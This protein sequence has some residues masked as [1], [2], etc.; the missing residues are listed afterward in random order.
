[1]LFGE[2][3][4]MLRMSAHMSQTELAKRLNVSPR[5]I[6][7]YES[8]RSYPKQEENYTKIAELFDVSADFLITT[9]TGYI[10]NAEDKRPRGCQGG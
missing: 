9:A 8:G 4:R 6:Q 2:K 10:M 3:L 7:N 1:M 5:K